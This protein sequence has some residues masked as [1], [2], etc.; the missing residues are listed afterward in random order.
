[1]D[2][3]LGTH[4]LLGEF[5]AAYGQH[6][7]DARFAELVE[8]LSE[9][10]AEFRSWW[11]HYDARQSIT[12]PLVIRHRGAGT[13]RLDVTELRVGAYPSLTLAVQVPVGPSDR[14]K[15]ARL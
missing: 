12:G 7:G 3:I 4:T 14:R 2:G 9:A 11:T 13:T 8:A 10:S 6:S 1:M 5:R 15:L